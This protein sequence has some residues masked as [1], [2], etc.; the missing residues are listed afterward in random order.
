MTKDKKTT[1]N[2]NKKQHQPSKPFFLKRLFRRKKLIFLI[3]APIGIVIL[4]YVYIFKDFPTPQKLSDYQESAQSTQIFDRNGKLLY[5]IYSDQNRIIVPIS[6][7]PLYLKQSTIAIEDKD[8]YSHKG[9]DPIGGIVR[10]LKEI[11]VN[12]KLQGGSTITQ[13]L[14]KSALLTSDRTV[15]RKIKE[16]LLAF[17]AERLYSK[18]QILEM[19][20]NQVPYGGTAWGV[21]AASQTYF[22]KNVADLTLAESALLAGLPA[23]P[24]FYSPFGARPELAIERQH[25]VLRRMVEEKYITS[26]EAENAKKEEL[27]FKPPSKEDIKAPHFVM[28][29]KEQLVN[30]YGEKMVEHGGLKV[31]TTLD[32]PLQEEAQKIVAD[33]V[34]K[35][36]KLKVGNGATLITRPK[37][38]EIL[39]MVGSYDYFAPDSG[40]VHVAISLR[41]PGSSIKPINYAVGIETKK[42]TAATPFLDT[43]T[44]FQTTGQ[45]PYCPKNYDNAFHGPV[46]LRFALANSFN[47]PAVKMLALNGLRDMV[48][49]ASA[50]GIT[51]FKDPGRYGLSLTLGGGEVKM[52]EMA[53]AFGV[54]ANAGIKKDLIAIIKVE[55]PTG[56][57]LEEIPEEK[58]NI[59]S[60][61]LIEGPRVL[62]AETTYIISHILLDD[63]ARS[64][65]FGSNSLLKIKDHSVSVKTGTTD[66]VRDNWTIGYTQEYLAV[67]WVG[68]N[69]GSYMNSS[70]VSGVT[71][72]AP[73]WNK[74]MS[75][76]L[77]DK[78]ATFPKMPDGIVGK[79][80]CSI[81]GKLP[82]N[83]DAANPGCQTRFEYF[84]KGTEP[85]EKENL[86]EHILIDKG[87]NMPAKPDQ[88][89][90]VE[91]QEKQ[92]IR[93]PFGLLCLDCTPPDWNHATN[94]KADT[95]TR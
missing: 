93:D 47:I 65:M 54:F 79:I 73:I 83:D 1:I 10:A 64:Q 24:T 92:V 2:T 69:D 55:D 67:T 20:L 75:F 71:G 38:G 61:L 62:S 28:Y 16:I 74:V 30:K 27:K 37:T 53:T 48:A 3:L 60:S 86:K 72:A 26:E 9:V 34:E 35:L 8:F 41:Q 50:M 44:C 5:N 57:V 17:W 70:L 95:F 22:N 87:I 51:T 85:K 14:I 63:G 59:N 13:Q 52:T 78:E 25:E 66:D 76:V 46:Q 94:V 77:K 7:I 84:I 80:I 12:R 91:T 45:R 18:D 11:V 56:K 6:T 43:P 81:S 90:N 58:L 23:A 36:R 40:N 49:T 32:L 4:S 89:E 88:T 29:V 33:E 15:Q 19:Y 82:P 68:N 42:V 31:K 39:A 21:Q